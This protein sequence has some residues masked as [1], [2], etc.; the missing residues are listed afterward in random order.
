V[1][2]FTQLSQDPNFLIKIASI[3]RLKG[4]DGKLVASCD[5]FVAL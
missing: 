4:L 2:I 3:P 1:T 5:V